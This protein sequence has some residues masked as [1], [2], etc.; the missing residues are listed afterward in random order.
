MIET[1]ASPSSCSTLSAGGRGA[2]GRALEVL[3]EPM[4]AGDGFVVYLC[5]ERGRVAARLPGRPSPPIL[6]GERVRLPKG[7]KPRGR[8]RS[9]APLYLLEPKDLKP[10]G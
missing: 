9:G 10:L 5:G 4:R 7:A 2:G 1:S 6:R 3:S 8:D